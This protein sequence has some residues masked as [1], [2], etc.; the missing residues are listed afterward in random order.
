MT[1][2]TIA[3]WIVVLLAAACGGKSGNRTAGQ[4]GGGGAVGAGGSSVVANPDAGPGGQPGSGGIMSMGGTGRATG[5]GGAGGVDAPAA[6]DGAAGVPGQGG[7]GGADAPLATG[8]TAGATGVPFVD[9]AVQGTRACEQGEAVYWVSPTGAAAWASCKSATP[10]ADA[11]ACAIATANQSAAAGDT[12]CLRGGTYGTGIA[13]RNDGAEAARLT[14]AGY[15][16]EDAKFTGA[17]TGIKLTGRAYVTVDAVNVDGAKVFADL[18]G[19][20]HV[21]ILNSKLVNSSDTGGWPVGVRMY[22]DAHHNRLA[23]CTIGNSGYMTS[24]DD[25]GG[26]MNLGNWENATDSTGRN[27]IEQ[28]HFYHGG[29]HIIEVASSYNIIR[30][31]AFHNENWTACARDSTNNLCGN[32]DLIVSRDQLNA[33]WN[34][35]EGN[36]I[37]FSGA[38]IDDLVGSTGLSVRSPHTIVRNNMFYGTD[39]AGLGLY[40]DSSE[41][42]D[43]RSTYVYHNVFYRNGI[44]PLSADDLRY[45]FGLTFDNV[46]GTRAPIPIT[47]CAVKNNLFFGNAGGDIFF[48]YTDAAAQSV[49][50]N[51]YAVVK[52]SNQT[53]MV[54]VTLPPDNV[55]SSADPLFADVASAFTVDNLERFDFRLQAGSPAIDRG[56]FLTTTTAGGSGTVIPVADPSYFID[57]FGI[58]PG[59]EIQLEGQSATARIVSID[60]AGKQLTLDRTLTYAAGNGVTMKYSG[61]APDIGAF[62]R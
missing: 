17:I 46:A 61:P 8:G 51:Y 29:H 7:R 21:W 14:F 28:C 1:R 55:Q 20:H 35:F 22:N 19:A 12:V 10:L 2:R 52:G 43:A 39:G 16:G 5:V 48:Y 30:N 23:G 33:N 54:S 40:V 11:V 9:A 56:V 53:G 18:I 13:P 15:A 50:G 44:S 32:R 60:Y 57:G 59:D 47:G 34:V 58:V 41:T 49:G 37:A 3:T 4:D 38:S 42:Y 45:T 27:L 36:R 26:V 31:N 25:K 24:D 62:E 6:T